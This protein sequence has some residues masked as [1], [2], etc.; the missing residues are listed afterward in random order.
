M[1][2]V[3]FISQTERPPI[4]FSQERGA[5]FCHR[6]IYRCRR[7]SKTKRTSLANSKTFC[8]RLQAHLPSTA[9][10]SVSAPIH[11]TVRVHLGQFGRMK[12]R[13]RPLAYQKALRHLRADENE[14]SRKS[15]NRLRR[16]SPHE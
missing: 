16:L 13:R 6:F 4:L 1:T 7:F 11:P 9:V 15:R 3:F 14:S 2:C 12:P 8:R 5:H 10:S